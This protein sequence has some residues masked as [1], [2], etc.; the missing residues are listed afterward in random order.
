[1]LRDF[2]ASVVDN[3]PDLLH[4]KPLF[5]SD[6]KP[7]FLFVVALLLAEFLQILLGPVRADAAAL[8][9]IDLVVAVTIDDFV[10]SAVDNFDDLLYPNLVADAEAELTVHLVNAGTNFVL[11]AAIPF[12]FASSALHTDYGLACSSPSYAAVIADTCQTLG[13]K[14]NFV[15]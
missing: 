7:L 2:G 8:E 3:W 15:P 11:A 4:S 5:G 9:P 13:N 10:A 12:G 1:M 6:L 14:E